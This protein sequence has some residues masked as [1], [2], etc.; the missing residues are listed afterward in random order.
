M[1]QRPYLIHFAC[2]G[3]RRSFK[4]S[5]AYGAKDYVKRCP[6]CGGRAIDLGRHF[7]APK[8][9]DTEQ[10]RKVKYL[11]AAGF[12]FQ[13]VRNEKTGQV[14]YP[15]TLQEAREFVDRYRAQ[16]WTERLLETLEIL[17]EARP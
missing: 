5:V 16:A 2:F 11:V 9:S 4:R 1:P 17:A 15:E 8:A 10:W 3:C 6:H 12:F 7:K 13:H 14:P